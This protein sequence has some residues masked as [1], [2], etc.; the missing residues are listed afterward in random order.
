MNGIL[1]E[2][3]YS[4]YVAPPSRMIG[5]NIFTTCEFAINN[6]TNES[7]WLLSFYLTYGYHPYQ[8]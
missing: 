6:A 4:H 1:E 7:T 3:A 2:N 8:S 5:T